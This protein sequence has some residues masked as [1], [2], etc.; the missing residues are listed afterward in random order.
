MRMTHVPVLLQETLEGLALHPGARAIDWHAWR[1]RSQRGDPGRHQSRTDGS[2][3][4]DRD[5]EAI[6]Q[7][8]QRLARF[9]QRAVLRHGSFGEIGSAIAREA[10]FLSVQ[11]MLLDLGISSDQ[12]DAADRG[13]SFQAEGPLDMRMDTDELAHGRR[14]RQRVV[15]GADRRR[16]LSVCG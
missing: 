4:V 1:W 5:Q 9:G 15:A 3:S 8:Q 13:F 14:D 10:G 11:G 7:A 6:S 16:D 12:L 2:L